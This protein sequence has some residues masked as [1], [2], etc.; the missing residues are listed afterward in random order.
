MGGD[1]TNCMIFGDISLS[2]GWETLSSSELF[3][4]W[5]GNI[6]G[7][8]IP[9]A[10]SELLPPNHWIV[11]YMAYVG[12]DGHGHCSMNWE[13]LIF[14]PVELPTKDGGVLVVWPSPEHPANPGLSLN[15]WQHVSVVIPTKPAEISWFHKSI[16]AVHLGKAMNFMKIRWLVDRPVAPPPP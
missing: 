12:H 15:L 7:I 14:W 9:L 11:W 2:D 13:I 5:M 3:P 6:L 8:W 1:K 16:G 10:R 4:H